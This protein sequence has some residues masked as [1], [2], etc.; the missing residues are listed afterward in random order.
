MVA[1][2]MIRTITASVRPTPDAV[3]QVTP[4]HPADRPREKRHPV[5]R[6][7]GDDRSRPVASGKEER[8]DDRYR[9]GV[10][11]KVVP[12]H[13]VAHTPRRKRPDRSPRRPGF[14]RRRRH[15]PL[16]LPL[17]PKT[18]QR[19]N[20]ALSAIPPS[21]HQPP[22][23]PIGIDNR[24]TVRRR[25][26]KAPCGDWYRQHDVGGLEWASTVWNWIGGDRWLRSTCAVPYRSTTSSRRS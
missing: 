6:E 1:P 14:T 11:R 26:C 9:I 4:E 2:P 24:L 13:K 18:N 25:A 5:E 7:G 10:D 22:I 21:K 12:L 20:V 19:P 17:E 8:R 3:A 23:P 15:Q 16:S